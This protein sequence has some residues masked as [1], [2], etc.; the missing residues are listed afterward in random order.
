MTELCKPAM[1]ILRKAGLEW[2]AQCALHRFRTT[3]DLTE[4]DELSLDQLTFA[5]PLTQTGSPI[6][7]RIQKRISEIQGSATGSG[8]GSSP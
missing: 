3:S 7:E 2:D 8:P 1:E 5:L 4:M 6:R